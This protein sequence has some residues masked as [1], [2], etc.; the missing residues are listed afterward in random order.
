MNRDGPRRGSDGTIVIG[1]ILLGLGVFFLLRQLGII[2]LAFS[3]VWP[4][5]LIGIGAWI[6][7]QALRPP[8]SGRDRAS[9]PRDGVDQ[10]EL[11]MKVGAGTFHLAGGG[12]E[13]VEVISAS[14]DL[15]IETTRDGRRA[16]VELRR[17]GPW[18]P[19]TSAVVSEWWVRIGAGV[20]V[21]LEIDGGAGRFDL[22][23]GGTASV[24]AKLVLGAAEARLV[25]PRPVGDIEVQGTLGAASLA[26]VVPPGV[27]ARVQT[28]GLISVEGERETPGFA[29][30]TDRI[31]VRIDGGAA[32]LTIS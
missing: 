21:S 28:S 30:A 8:A 19:P 23:L 24:G 14:R 4:I 17:T 10:L 18:L 25:L 3:V 16:R 1:L 9:V 11:R 22:D 15:A 31:R 2:D 7:V 29:D 13:L 6:V 32:S 20:T 26:L 27:E 12:T 5:I